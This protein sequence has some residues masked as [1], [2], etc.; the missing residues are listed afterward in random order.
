MDPQ[1]GLQLSQQLLLQVA[2]RPPKDACVRR[3]SH[4]KPHARHILC[5]AGAASV[6]EA[7]NSIGIT[8]GAHS[9]GCGERLAA[10]F[11]PS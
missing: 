1:L 6:R 3:N 5:R 7:C 8:K 4:G 10:A 9:S 11:F 2:Y